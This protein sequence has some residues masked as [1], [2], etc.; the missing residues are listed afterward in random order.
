[1]RFKFGAHIYLWIDRWSDQTVRLL[2]HAAG[3]GLECL[4]IAIGDDVPFTPRL[5]RQHARSAGMEF[6]MGPGGAWPMECDISDDDPANRKLGLDWHRRQID[7]AGEAG[8]IAYCGAIYAHPGRV[9]RRVPPPDELPRT[10]GNLHVLAEHSRRAGLKLVIEPMSHFRTHLV[11]TPQ[12]VMRLTELADHPNL[13]VLLDTYHMVTEVRD[14]AQAVRIV[15]PKLWGIHACENDRGV[16]GGGLVPW[17]ALFASLGRVP[18]DGH[19]LLETYNSSLGDF[20]P[21]RGMFHNVCPDG[22]AFVR[23]G[24]AFLRRCQAGPDQGEPPC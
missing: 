1:M 8:A 2:D 4:E 20:A 22:D 7:L 6:T 21:G 24:L 17:D 11:N 19:M 16:P 12:Q 5:T 23:Q 3:L 15:S 13:Y 18:G 10:A 14:F 9:M